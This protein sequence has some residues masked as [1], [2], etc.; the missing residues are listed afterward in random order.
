MRHLRDL[1]RKLHIDCYPDLYYPEL[2][3]LHK[4]YKEFFENAPVR[5]K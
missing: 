5:G 4:G 3:L 2:Y 1:D